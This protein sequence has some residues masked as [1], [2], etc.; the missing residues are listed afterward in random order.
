MVKTL[1]NN[2]VQ[3]KK[4]CFFPFSKNRILHNYNG[5]HQ[6][7]QNNYGSWY[8]VDNLKCVLHVIHSLYIIALEETFVPFW[9]CFFESFE[10]LTLQNLL[11]LPVLK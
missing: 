6:Q 11:N 9:K 5:M 8:S 1:K 4:H 10:G 7:D 3:Q 2:N